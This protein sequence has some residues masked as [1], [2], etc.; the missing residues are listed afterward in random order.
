MLTRGKTDRF[1]FG[2]CTLFL[3]IG[4]SAL[5]IGGCAGAASV[6][7]VSAQSLPVTKTLAWDPNPP[8]EGVLHYTVTM[9]GVIVGSPTATTQAV[10]FTTPGAH[11]LTVSATNQWDTGPASP[12][13]VTV[14]IPTMTVNLRLQ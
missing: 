10:I 12:L 13:V 5:L 4:Y 11:T 2:L 14:I 9:D 8:A 3:L 6:A 7:I 1:L